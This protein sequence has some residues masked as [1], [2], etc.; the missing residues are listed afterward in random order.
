MIHNPLLVQ[1]NHINT[2]NKKWE[3]KINKEDLK[4]NQA[5]TLTNIKSENLIKRRLQMH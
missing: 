2:M 1:A 5:L 3:S 4:T